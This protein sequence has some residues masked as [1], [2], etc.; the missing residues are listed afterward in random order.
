MFFNYRLYRG[1][2]DMPKYVVGMLGRI[3]A[4][5]EALHAATM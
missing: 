3:G 4:F 2:V 5:L 1:G